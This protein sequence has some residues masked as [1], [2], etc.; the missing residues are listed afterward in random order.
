MKNIIVS[1]VLFFSSEGHLLA[2]YPVSIGKRDLHKIYGTKEIYGV[3]LDKDLIGQSKVI[4]ISELSNF[5]HGDVN[6]QG[7]IQFHEIRIFT[8]CKSIDDERILEKCQ[9]SLEIFLKQEGG[10]LGSINLI[11]VR[12]SDLIDIRRI[13]GL[14]KD[15]SLVWDSFLRY[16]WQLSYFEKFGIH[17]DFEQVDVIFSVFQRLSSTVKY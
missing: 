9:F 1:S 16:K 10:R 3:T 7:G 13:F 2:E 6:I 11:G 14:P 17:F 8:Y 12:V 5:I 4:S 15:H